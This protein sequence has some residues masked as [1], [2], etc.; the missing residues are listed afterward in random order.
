MPIISY[1]IARLTDR[2]SYY[3]N[4]NTS[5]NKTIKKEKE[6]NVINENSNLGPIKLK[7]SSVETNESRGIEQL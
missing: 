2:F 5:S 1:N 3:R 4:N 7:E 6:I